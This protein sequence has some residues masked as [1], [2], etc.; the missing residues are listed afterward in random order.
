MAS[1]INFD[2][3]VGRYYNGYYAMMVV[4]HMHEFGT[5]EEQL[6]RIAVKNHNNA[7]HN[8][9]AQEHLAFTIEDVMRS[10]YIACPLNHHAICVLSYTPHHPN[11]SP[12]N[13]P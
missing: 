13:P 5:T 2:Y 7:L 12:N 3:P 11:L 1:D 4:R 8:P 10:D 6:A 9:Y